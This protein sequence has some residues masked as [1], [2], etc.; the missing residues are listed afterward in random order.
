MA[1]N[2]SLNQY[3]IMA[4]ARPT[5]AAILLAALFLSAASGSDGG[6]IVDPDWTRHVE[7]A[8]SG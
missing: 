4:L 5:A 2:K 3:I 7:A 1:K 6:F 8:P